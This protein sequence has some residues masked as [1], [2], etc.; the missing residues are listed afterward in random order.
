MSAENTEKQEVEVDPILQDLSKANADISAAILNTLN[1]IYILKQEVD[2][3]KEK[4]N[5]KP[6]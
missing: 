6:E 3:L 5:G 4:V 2:E 1:I